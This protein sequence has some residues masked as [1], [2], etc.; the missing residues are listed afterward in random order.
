MNDYKI[1]LGRVV[2]TSA[3]AEWVRETNNDVFV[4]K[5]L[6]RHQSGDWGDMCE[7]DVRSNDFACDP[8]NAPQRI[9]SQY[10]FDEDTKIWII[11]EWDRSTTTVLFPSDY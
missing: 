9:L 10:I 1:E 11:T 4:W 2:M 5:S 3:I 7:E 8:N 6:A